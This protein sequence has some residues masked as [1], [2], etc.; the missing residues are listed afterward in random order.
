MSF[1]I[2]LNK[3]IEYYKKKKI[4]FTLLLS[5]VSNN[6]VR[7]KGNENLNGAKCSFMHNYALL[8]VLIDCASLLH[9]GLEKYAYIRTVILSLLMENFVDF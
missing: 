8:R 4:V 3:T 9:L 2:R 7:R 5:A 1:L 6:V